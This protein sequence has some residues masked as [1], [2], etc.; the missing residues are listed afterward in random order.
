M[1]ETLRIVAADYMLRRIRSE[2]LEMPGLRLTR[3][4]AQRL[5]GL[6]EHTC[7]Q[8]LDSLTESRFLRRT[9]TTFLNRTDGAMYARLTDGA[10]AAPRLRMASAGEAGIS[11]SSARVATLLATDQTWARRL[12]GHTPP[13]HRG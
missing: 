11:T 1:S 8:L 4:Q 6:D 2:Y 7:A 13:G 3:R 5:W 9:E 10:V 12:R